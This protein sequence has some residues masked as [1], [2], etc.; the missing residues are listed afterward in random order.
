MVEEISPKLL[1]YQLS[2]GSV[3]SIFRLLRDEVA[4]LIHQKQERIRDEDD[5]ER[6]MGSAHSGSA[7]PRSNEDVREWPHK[8]D[9][10][11]MMIDTLK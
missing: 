1:S 7:S 9:D 2:P 5:E 4:S 11:L 3:N 8:V 10:F 6:S